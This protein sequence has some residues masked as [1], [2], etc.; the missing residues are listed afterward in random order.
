LGKLKVDVVGGVQDSNRFKGYNY[1]WDGSTNPS[2]TNELGMAKAGWHSV[3]VLDSN[4]CQLALT[5]KL[6][7]PTKLIG[8]IDGSLDVRCYKQKN[9]TIY[10]SATGGLPF[11]KYLWYDTALVNRTLIGTG[12]ILDGIGAGFY[13][14]VV[15]DR[16]NCSDTVKDII[17]ILQPDTIVISLT[18]K[19]RI[20]CNGG[21]NGKL[22]VTA[23]GGNGLYNYEWLIKPVSV[24]DSFIENLPG[25]KYFVRATDKKGCFTDTAFVLV[26]PVKNSIIV[27][28]DSIEICEFDTLQ[29][30]AQILNAAQYNWRN[31]N[32]DFGWQVDSSLT[33]SGIVK[34]QGGV[35]KVRA[36]DRFGC[37][38]ST[39]VSVI[40]NPLPTI[41]AFTKP[42]IACI[43]SSCEL[44][45]QGGVKY[46]WYKERYNPVYGRDTLPGNLSNYIISSV[47]KSDT[48]RYFVKGISLR[49]CANETDLRV[50][51]G[52]DSILIPSDAQV[53]SGAKFIL[54][55]SCVTRLSA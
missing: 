7:E 45:A 50:R 17:Q 30:G 4:G 33:I 52:L 26:D 20:T 22:R 12:A 19:M 43:G 9:G 15:L 5:F 38:D 53:C 21:Q 34:N 48:G 28:N 18:D 35:Y 6:N 42:T 29:L 36:I 13:K 2:P 55:A 37:Q 39:E 51:V 41:K 24:K 44:I 25:G 31:I 46:T 49:G 47:T 54:S 1:Y 10:G 27:P 14:L 32:T 40:V 8:K 11:Y 3:M 16:N 23:N